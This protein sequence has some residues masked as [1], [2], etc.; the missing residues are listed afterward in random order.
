MDYEIITPVELKYLKRITVSQSWVFGPLAC[1]VVLC[2][3]TEQ[4]A[5]TAVFEGLREFEIAKLSDG[6]CLGPLKILDVRDRQWENVN[7]KVKDY[8]EEFVSF[9]CSA[10]SVDEKEVA[11][12]IE[13]HQK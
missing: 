12:V 8:E 6:R 2:D 1:E 9:Y 3:Q 13:N 4:T 10:F 11:A 5:V 7:Y